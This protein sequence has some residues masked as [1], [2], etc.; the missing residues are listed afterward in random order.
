MLE[1]RLFLTIL[2][3]CQFCPVHFWSFVWNHVR[4]G[5]SSLLFWVVA[6]NRNQHVNTKAIVIAT[7]FW[8]NWYI[9]W[10]DSGTGGREVG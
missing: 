8:E 5:F 2:K 6:S 1:I 9:I 3:R 7:I 4:F 10:G